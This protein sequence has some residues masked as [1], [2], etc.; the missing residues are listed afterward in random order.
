MT[1]TIYKTYTI[2]YSIYKTTTN[3]TIYTKY[4]TKYAIYKNCATTHKI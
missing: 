2:K 4:T 3:F 1:C